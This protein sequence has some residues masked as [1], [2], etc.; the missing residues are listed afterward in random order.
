[1]DSGDQN[2]EAPEPVCGNDH[3]G[4]HWKRFGNVFVAAS[5]LQPARVCCGSSCLLMVR[6]CVVQ[7]WVLVLWFTIAQHSFLEI[8]THLHKS[9]G[10]DA[11]IKCYMMIRRVFVIHLACWRLEYNVRW[12]TLYNTLK[13]SVEF[14]SSLVSV[15]PDNEP[16]LL[17][18]RS[19]ICWGVFCPSRCENR[20]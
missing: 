13:F 12:L 9:L 7:G 17:E 6:K 14:N 11:L 10:N 8:S 15:G 18:P 5:D 1:M 19:F 16:L 20:F 4:F 2:I 3:R